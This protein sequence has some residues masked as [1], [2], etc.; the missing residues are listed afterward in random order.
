MTPVQAMQQ[1]LAGEHAA[2]HLYGVLGARTSESASAALHASLE[3]GH[4]RHR[5]RRDQ[6]RLLLRQSG[7]EPA[8]AAAAYELPRAST[9]PRVAAAALAVERASMEQLAAMVAQT[10][11]A[12]RR[13]AAGELTW[14]ALQALS[15]GAQPETWPGAPELAT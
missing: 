11:A 7:V 5:A 4:R 2:L 10:A 13:W 1:T 9:P 3:A 12:P 14:S 15:L 6:L 8:P